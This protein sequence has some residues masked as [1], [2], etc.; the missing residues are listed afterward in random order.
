MNPDELLLSEEHAEAVEELDG[1]LDR[2][3]ELSPRKARLLEQRYFGG[4]KLEECA[5]AL[6]VS[7]ATVKNDLKLGRAW[8]A[9]ELRQRADR[10]EAISKTDPELYDEL[11]SLLEAHDE[12]DELLGGLENLVSEPDFGATPTPDAGASGP[13]PYGLMGRTVGRYEVTG[14]LGAGGMGVLYKATDTQLD[15]AVA[16]KFLPP[17]WSANE[18]FKQRFVREARA[19]AALDHTNICAIYEVG[20]T[21]EGQLFIAMAHYEGETLH[22][23]I[24]RGPVGVDEARGG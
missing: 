10:L 6:G 22:Q 4:L 18:R 15:R 7:L 5:E 3:A 16:L 20:E 12:A 11:K 21:E 8:L 23:T 2:L 9:R 17:Q 14:L 1:A 24:A 19:A 13:D